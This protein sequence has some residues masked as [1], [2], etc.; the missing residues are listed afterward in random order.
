M[1]VNKFLPH[2]YVLPEDD[3]NRQIA[4]GFFL[5][6]FLLQRQFYIL[7]V[8]GGWN[9][10]LQRFCSIYAAEMEKTATR[11][12]VLLI[13]LDN[14]VDRLADAQKRIP[15]QLRGRVFILGV[16]SE[17]EDLKPQLG[18]FESIGLA[19]AKDCREDADS[20]WAHPLLQHN[21]PELDRLR[22]QVRRI[23]FPGI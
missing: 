10:V 14:R 6:G 7:E 9:E 8:A 11:Y 22:A 20:I 21:K 3:A 1:S 5:D 13:D 15:E 17:P 18:S 16:L 23:L 4:N 19:M 2:V 12:M